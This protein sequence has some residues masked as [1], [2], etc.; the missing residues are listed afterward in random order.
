LAWGL[1]ALVS[2]QV[3]IPGFVQYSGQTWLAVVQQAPEIADFLLLAFRLVGALNVAAAVPLIAIA[4]TAFRARERW[5]WWTLLVGNTLALGA[6]IAYDQFT[7]A[8]GPF[9]NRRMGCSCAGLRGVGFHVAPLGNEEAGC[10]SSGYRRDVFWMHRL[11]ETVPQQRHLGPRVLVSV[12]VDLN[13]G[14]LAGLAMGSVTPCR[15]PR[16]GEPDRY[17]GGQTSGNVTARAKT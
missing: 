16:R 2:P 1:L 4:L 12:A 17:P 9:R 3:L 11:G 15:L 13:A 6:P 14:R 5:A 10:E 7:G 8:I